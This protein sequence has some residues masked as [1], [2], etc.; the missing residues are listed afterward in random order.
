MP[1]LKDLDLDRNPINKIL[2]Y[3]YDILL[4]KKLK[5]LDNELITEQD[6]ETAC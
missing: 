1:N 4:N 2:N 3:K 5:K 6:Y